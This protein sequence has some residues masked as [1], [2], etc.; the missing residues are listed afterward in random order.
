MILTP[1]LTDGLGGEWCQAKGTSCNSSDRSLGNLSLSYCGNRTLL[2]ASP[3]QISKARTHPPRYQP[4]PQCAHERASL[5]AHRELSAE[6][7]PLSVCLSGSLCSLCDSKQGI[8]DEIHFTKL[9]Y[10]YSVIRIPY[11]T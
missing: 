3:V 7:A 10:M 6:L 5:S 2:C 4:P 1:Q 8:W 9:G 11:L